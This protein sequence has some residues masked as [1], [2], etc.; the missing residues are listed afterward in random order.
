MLARR[1]GENKKHIFA[2][3]TNYTQR[4][5]FVSFSVLKDFTEFI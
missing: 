1:G 3:N 4:C 5:I 2:R